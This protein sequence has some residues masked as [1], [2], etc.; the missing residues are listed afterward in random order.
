M[1]CIRRC[2]YDD[3]GQQFQHTVLHG[4]GLARM[5]TAAVTVSQCYGLCRLRQNGSVPDHALARIIRPLNQLAFGNP[6]AFD[7]M[8]GTGSARCSCSQRAVSISLSRSMPVSNPARAKH[9]KQILRR[10]VACRVRRKR[11]AAEST[12]AGV[13]DARRRQSRLHTR[14][15]PQYCACCGSGSAAE[16]PAMPRCRC[17]DKRSD[18]HR[19]RYTDRVGDSDLHRLCDAASRVAIS[20]HALLTG[21]SP[22]NGQPNATEIVTC[23]RM[24]AACASGAISSHARS[25][26]R[27]SR[28]DCCCRS[29]RSQP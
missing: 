1:Q 3:S 16:L 5:E 17:L 18:L 14:S 26:L 28:P 11:T 13:Q 9:V 20:T 6:P 7:T 23:A 22:S 8:P 27:S 4:T 15:R 21:T 29:C 12:D 25:C 2:L 19:H 24:P 10:D